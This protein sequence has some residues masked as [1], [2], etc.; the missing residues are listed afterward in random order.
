M[1][2][3]FS[4][5]DEV[6]RRLHGVREEE[7]SGFRSRLRNLQRIG[8]SIAPIEGGGR[9]KNYQGA[10]V[11]KLA[12]AVELLQAGLPPERAAILTEAT[13]RMVAPELLKARADIKANARRPRYLVSE[14]SLLFPARELGTRQFRVLSGDDLAK[15]VADKNR[16]AHQYRVLAINL[17][18]LLDR[19]IIA[20]REAGMDPNDLLTEMDQ[21]PAGAMN[22]KLAQSGFIGG[23]DA[24]DT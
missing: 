17:A 1:E 5:V 11:L 24:S 8:L 15:L 19:T 7:A 22:P 14:P 16:S 10:S 4:E 6:L 2:L 18:G 13:W 3:Y 23:A 21:A 12:M 20:F 9:K